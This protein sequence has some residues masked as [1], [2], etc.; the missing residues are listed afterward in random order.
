MSAEG[1]VEG[2]GICPSELTQVPMFR[3]SLP[4]EEGM[5]G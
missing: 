1:G 4:L 2:W 5:E 3:E